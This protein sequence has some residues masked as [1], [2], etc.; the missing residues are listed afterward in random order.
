[1]VLQHQSLNILHH[2]QEKDTNQWWNWR[3]NH[4]V[5]KHCLFLNRKPS[6]EQRTVTLFST[7]KQQ[8][9]RDQWSTFCATLCL[10][11][12]SSLMA[13]KKKINIMSTYEVAW[14]FLYLKSFHSFKLYFSRTWE[15][16]V[17]GLIST[18]LG[19]PC[20]PWILSKI[21]HKISIQIDKTFLICEKILLTRR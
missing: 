2:E 8:I 13:S 9:F 3:I 6:E 10:R 14:K 20:N 15:L 12:T 21:S 11:L 18:S 1:M 19:V 16:Y 4:Q 5:R 7:E 17:S